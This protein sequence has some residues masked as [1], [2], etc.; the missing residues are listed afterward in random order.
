MPRPDF[1]TLLW[2]TSINLGTWVCDI[3]VVK[4]GPMM[5]SIL[6]ACLES[7]NNIL[8]MQILSS[9]LVWQEVAVDVLEEKL[10]KVLFARETKKDTCR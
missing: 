8:E 7:N 2:D 6:D 10:G 9:T 4:D 3:L 5:S 1:V